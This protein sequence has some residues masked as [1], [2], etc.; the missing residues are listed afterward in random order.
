MEFEPRTTQ[1]TADAR[2][3][4]LLSGVA[5]IALMVAGGVFWR[6]SQHRE[7]FERQ[8]E[9]QRRLGAVGEMV[10]VL[11]HEIR[12]PLAS[13]K[14]HAQLL[15][16]QLEAGAAERRRADRIVT[17]AGRL[18]Q[19]TTNLLDFAR[20]AQLTRLPIDPVALLRMA[21]EDVDPA[22]IDIETAEA[23]P[24]WS[25][26]SNGVRRA[27]ANLLRNAVQASEET[28]RVQVRAAVERDQLIYVVRDHGPGLPAGQEATIFDPFVTTRATG[29]GLGLSVALRVVRLHGGTISAS[30][31]SD[32]GAVFRIAIPRE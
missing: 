11:A 7:R 6:M 28:G 18:E 24:R 32:G 1:L 29:A 21:V 4:F 31:H 23:L 25:L 27:L 26:D 12:N 19:L 2:R 5:A 9:Q 10:A 20:S 22:R 8:L 15:A 14:G 16:E 30:N 17:E 13:L 3:M